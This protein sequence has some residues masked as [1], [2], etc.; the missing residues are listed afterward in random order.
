MRYPMRV[1]LFLFLLTAI[2]VYG[3]APTITGVT[4]SSAIVGTSVTIS[5]SHFGE[6]QGSSTVTFNGVAAKPTGWTATSIVVPVPAGAKDGNIVVTTA[7]GNASVPFTVQA[8]DQRAFEVLTGVG[9]VLAGVESTSYKV[10]TQNNA[11]SQANVGR[12][13]IEILLGG[14]FILPWHRTG[15]WIEDSFCTEAADKAHRTEA[16][17]KPECRTG[18]DIDYKNYRPWE[19]FLSIRFAPASDQTINGFV[20]GGGYRITKYFSLLGGYSV[21]PVDEPSHGFRVAASQVTAANPTTFPYNH[22][23]ASDLLNNKP[24]AFD[25][26]PLF[27]YNANGVTTTK[28]FPTSPTVTHYRSGIYFGV[29]IPLNL[30]ALFKPSGGK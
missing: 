26:F 21:T 28:I 19:A 11:L 6:S 5:G 3:Q 17:Q 13:K 2:E 7:A 9:A 30:T 16:R 29:G 22:Y 15:R 18:G 10:D 14:G 25:G 24:G 27:L 8:Y 23:N 4:P 12:K 1:P 20:I